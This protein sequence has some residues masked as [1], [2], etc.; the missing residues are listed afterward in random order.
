[1]SV[2]NASSIQKIDSDDSIV[3]FQRDAAD[4]FDSIG[5]EETFLSVARWRS[6]VNDACAFSRNHRAP[7]LPSRTIDKR[8]GAD[9]T[10]IAATLFMSADASVGVRIATIA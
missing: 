2:E 7:K 10:V 8:T 1:M 6:P 3:A 9:R 4:F 5:Q